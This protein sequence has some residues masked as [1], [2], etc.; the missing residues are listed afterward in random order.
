MSTTAFQKP[1]PRK[2]SRGSR[3]EHFEVS[4][5]FLGFWL[6]GAVSGNF[7]GKPR[8]LERIFHPK[9]PK[10]RKIAF[11]GSKLSFRGWKI[12]VRYQGK[13]PHL[14]SHRS[15][16]SKFFFPQKKKKSFFFLKF[17]FG[18]FFF[19]FFFQI[20]FFRLFFL[21]EKSEKSYIHSKC[22]EKSSEFDGDVLSFWREVCF[23]ERPFDAKAHGRTD[24]RTH[25]F[26]GEP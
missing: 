23:R 7:S 4:F 8:I 17:F 12:Q 3:G 1:K 20:F 24:G 9:W 16:F 13:I 26:E 6:L 14:L 21:D 18:F 10:N 15:I 2:I 5:D 11:P 22:A 25:S 19:R